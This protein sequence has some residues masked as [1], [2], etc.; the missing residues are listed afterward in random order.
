MSYRQN[1]LDRVVLRIDFPESI[2]PLSAEL[3]A[4]FK[5][6]MIAIGPVI[7]RREVKTKTVHIEESA[8]AVRDRTLQEWWF[9]NRART[10]KAVVSKDY[11]FLEW[12]KYTNFTE[13]R[14]A[15][16]GM[17]KS[18]RSATQNIASARLGLRFIN[19][20]RL[21]GPDPMDWSGMIRPEMLEPSRIIPD[22]TAPLRVFQYAEWVCS[23]SLRLKLQ[24]GVHNPDYPA[25]VKQ[26]QFVID[27]DA[28]HVLPL[29]GEGEILAMADRAGVECCR[30]FEA[31]ITQ[32]LRGVMDAG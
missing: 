10:Q 14:T 15:F 12:D 27:I 18:F 6:T 32:E 1:F 3:P 29:A 28:F 30:V 11:A 19:I 21:A 23:D 7:E 2:D 5:E 25:P 4:G 24:Y 17:L 8:H 13:L 26:R 31:S 22:D 16:A 9:W 20:I